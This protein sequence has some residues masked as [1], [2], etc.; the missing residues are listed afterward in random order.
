MATAPAEAWNEAHLNSTRQMPQA[1]PASSPSVV[2]PTAKQAGHHSKPPFK[3]TSNSTTDATPPRYG[4]LDARQKNQAAADARRVN[5]NAMLQ[6]VLP[7]KG[8]AQPTPKSSAQADSQ[9]PQ[10]PSNPLPALGLRRPTNGFAMLAPQNSRQPANAPATSS[11]VTMQPLPQNWAVS[12]LG[13][14]P[15]GTLMPRT[16][17]YSAPVQIPPV[18]AVSNGQLPPAS[19]TGTAPPGP[20]AAC[21]TSVGEGNPCPS[22]TTAPPAKRARFAPHLPVRNSHDAPPAPPHLAPGVPGHLAPGPCPRNVRTGNAFAQGM[23]QWPVLP[24][25]DNVESVLA[26][27]DAQPLTFHRQVARPLCAV[28]VA[29]MRALGMRVRSPQS[30]YLLSQHWS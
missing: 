10:T 5:V 23:R 9:T 7:P 18:S 28:I 15:H 26:K 20:L 24:F 29:V 11:G 19:T 13:V 8:L 6:P 12:S 30:H 3:P 25:M 14:Q 27:G 22:S 16:V 4:G 2:E 17:V 1:T 21:T